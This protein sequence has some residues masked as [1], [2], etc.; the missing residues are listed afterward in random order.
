[1]GAS[2][3][4]AYGLSDEDHEPDF[5]DDGADAARPFYEATPLNHGDIVMRRHITLSF[6]E[7]VGVED[8]VLDAFRS[9]RRGVLQRHIDRRGCLALRRL[10]PNA[11]AR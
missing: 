6:R 3:H 9:G 7:V 10:T 5:T 4:W 2:L 1:M 11:P 8:E